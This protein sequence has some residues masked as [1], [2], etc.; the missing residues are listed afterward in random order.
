MTQKPSYCWQKDMYT[1]QNFTNIYT[2]D[3][4]SSLFDRE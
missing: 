4:H 3:V 1:S 2:Y